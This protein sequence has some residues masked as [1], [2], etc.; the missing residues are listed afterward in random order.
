MF[1]I[2]NLWLFLLATVALNLTPG[3]D[4]LYVI[5]RSI[6]QGK[7][8]GVVSS[9]GITVGALIHAVMAAFGLSFIISQS[10]LAFTV[11]KT[12]GALY[13]IYLGIKGFFMHRNVVI[14]KDKKVFSYK[15]MFW[16][17]VITDILNPKVALFFI[18][19]LPQFVNPKSGMITEQILF[20]GVL[21]NISGITVLLL[22]TAL[23]GYI[24]GWMEQHAFFEKMQK[25]FMPTSFV[26]LGIALLFSNR[27]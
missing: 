10:V 6:S 8:A 21:F 11:I 19:F 4:M 3:P 17:G 7:K 16:Q 5:S 14:K 1:D 15:R 20:L 24:A 23:F 2:S 12:A 27:E 9:F 25:W 18:S 13:L 22:T 26:G